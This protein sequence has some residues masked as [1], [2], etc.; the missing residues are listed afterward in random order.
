MRRHRSLYFSVHHPESKCT[1]I[2]CYCLSINRC[3]FLHMHFDK[4]HHNSCLTH[5]Y[6]QPGKYRVKKE[7]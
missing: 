3:V 2:S 1:S 4:L 5:I 7:F 6:F